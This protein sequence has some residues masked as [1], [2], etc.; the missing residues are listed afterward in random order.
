MLAFAVQTS[1]DGLV[2]RAVTESVPGPS[3]STR[4]QDHLP[5]DAGAVL[6]DLELGLDP[7]SSGLSFGCG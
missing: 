7:P 3:A 1:P 6:V 4:R 2:A 5:G